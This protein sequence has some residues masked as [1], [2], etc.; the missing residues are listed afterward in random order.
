ML[1]KSAE[2]STLTEL[3]NHA[4]MQSNVSLKLIRRMD[5]AGS[6]SPVVKMLGY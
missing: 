4:L 2:D 5:S 3:C 6:G 1:L